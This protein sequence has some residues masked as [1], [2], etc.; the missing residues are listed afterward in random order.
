M[1]QILCKSFIFSKYYL[2]LI[3]LAIWQFVFRHPT[4][5]L[6]LVLD[7]ISSVVP[8]KVL[9]LNMSVGGRVAQWLAYL[10]LDPAALG[11]IPRFLLKK[12]QMK[13]LSMLPPLINGAA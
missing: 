6:I 13:K 9:K 5:H 11:S 12:F 2:V 7:P 8:I 10:L 1:G 3:S 4:K